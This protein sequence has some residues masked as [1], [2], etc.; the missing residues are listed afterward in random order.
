[1]GRWF[2]WGM[3]LA[4]VLT[5]FFLFRPVSLG[6]SA[7]Y[8]TVEGV[9]MIPTYHTGDLIITHKESGY[10]VG[11]V[12]AY[13]IPQG[14][15]AAGHVVIHRIVGGNATA[16]YTTRGD[17]NSYTD[18]WRPKPSDIV[19]TPWL[20]VPRGGRFLF[21][22]RTPWVVAALAALLA[23]WMIMG[24]GKKEPSAESGERGS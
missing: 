6:G 4:V 23:V 1:M 18:L 16:G 17:N 11:Q 8:V 19:G 21:F 9:S 13:R 24:T 10:H 12:I 20:L 3:V 22:V 2:G 15:V 5:W 14:E 7:G